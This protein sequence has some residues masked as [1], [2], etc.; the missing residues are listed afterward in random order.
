MIVV[1]IEVLHSHLPIVRE[2]HVQQAPVRQTGCATNEDFA[3]VTMKWK[4][5][6]GGSRNAPERR[7]QTD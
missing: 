5:E 4:V 1:Q 3:S 6:S 7:N 2:G